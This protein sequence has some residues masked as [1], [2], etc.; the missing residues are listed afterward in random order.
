MLLGGVG[1]EV[2]ELELVGYRDGPVG[3]AGW[4]TSGQVGYPGLGPGVRVVEDPV[5]LPEV[6][7][8]TD[9]LFRWDP[10][11]DSLEVGSHV[12]GYPDPH[13][14]W[15]VGHPADSSSQARGQGVALHHVVPGEHVDG[16][17]NQAVGVR[18]PVDER[19]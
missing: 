2:V 10:G 5:Q 19:R 11:N 1:V 16:P 14:P 3:V 13:G 8:P 7:S 12:G 17:V 15:W 4:A 9:G 6:A 18:P